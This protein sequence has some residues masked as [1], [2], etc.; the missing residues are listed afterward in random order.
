MSNKERALR[1]AR[2]GLKIIP[3]WWINEDGICACGDKD[4]GGPASRNNPGKHPIAG[5]PGNWIAPKGRQDSTSDLNKIDNYWNQFPLAN[6]GLDC[7]GSGL[8]VV[9]IDL[10]KNKNGVLENGFESLDDWETTFKDKVTSKVTA[11]TGGGG[12]HIF[13]KSPSGMTTANSG[14]GKNYPGVDFKFNG[15]V[16]MAPSNHKSGSVYEWIDEESENLL[17]SGKVPPLPASILNFIRSGQ[18]ENHYSPYRY[19]APTRYADED[20]IEQMRDAL[21]CMNFFSLTDDE[22]LKVGMGLQQAL[23][24]GPGKALYFDWL[25]SNLGSKFNI[26][27]SERRWRSFKYRSGGRTIASFYEVAAQLGFVNEGKSRGEVINP[28]DFVFMEP[29]K[30]S[31]E[32]TGSYNSIFVMDDVSPSMHVDDSSPCDLIYIDESVTPSP[33]VVPKVIRDN[34]SKNTKSGDSMSELFGEIQKISNAPIDP[35]KGM[36]TSDQWDYWKEKFSGNKVLF[37]LFEYQVKNNSC[38]LPELAAAFSLSTI[39]GLLAGRF[40]V[41]TL[42]SNL[43]MMVVAQTSIGKSETMK[44]QAKVYQFAQDGER[45]G[46]KDIVSDK[47]FYNDLAINKARMFPI[48]EI[49]ELFSTLFGPKANASQQGIKR[50]LLD[51]FSAFGMEYNKTASKADAKNSPVMDLGKICPSIF[52]VTTPTK[53]YSAMSSGDIVDGMLNRLLCLE[54]DE[55]TPEG[56]LSMNVDLPREFTSW[57]LNVRGR[58]IHNGQMLVVGDN[59]VC[60]ELTLSDEAVRVLIAIK[61][62][63]TKKKRSHERYGLVWARLTELTKRVSIIFE[64]TER[65][66]SGEIQED[67]ILAAYKL[68]YWAIEKS[69]FIARNKIADSEEQSIMK[70][71]LYYIEKSHNGAF[72]Q[73]VVENTRLASNI[74]I[75]SM[76]LNALKDEQKIK[77]FSFRRP[78]ERGRPK[79]IYFTLDNLK[80]LSPELKN[81]LSGGALEI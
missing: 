56:K 17:L 62:I 67:S 26:K 81:Q 2:A 53:I 73:E 28:E 5:G 69:E 37:S 50:A 41:D 44:M 34:E 65:A 31:E 64:V 55:P 38:F 76:I 36:P 13:F 57:F 54:N 16:L 71:V 58:W 35:N 25:H 30:V 32:Y 49:G 46:P 29:T 47:G 40:R 43:Y 6:I 59:D 63:E 51:G 24:G 78:G 27:Y 4:C 19:T 79:K 14:L 18:D 45:M 42:T 70:E 12:Q 48:D 21:V 9:D 10:H 23:P 20:D 1:Y 33:D 8:F 22:K 3:I 11:H 66:Y 39:G 75:R 61:N 7:A 77:E 15:Y 80:Q 74:K 52:G 72:L 68:V 60:N